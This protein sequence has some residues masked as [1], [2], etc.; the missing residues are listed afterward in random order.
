MELGRDLTRDACCC[1]VGRGWGD[2]PGVCEVCPRNGT[3]KNYL[4]FINLNVTFFFFIND[5]HI[6]IVAFNVNVQ[7]SLNA[8]VQEGQV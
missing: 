8:C 3:S 7:G 1:S 6:L 4:L 5:L 2:S